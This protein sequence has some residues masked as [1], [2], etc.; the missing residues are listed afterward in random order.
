MINEIE[1]LHRMADAGD[2]TALYK[3][4]AKY[5]SGSGVEINQP[6]AASM[7]EKAASRGSADAQTQIGVFYAA[8]S[9]GYSQDFTKALEWYERAARS[10]HA[11]A[12]FNLALLYWEGEGVR[13]DRQRGWDLMQKASELGLRDRV[14]DFVE[15]EKARAAIRKERNA[16]FSSMS[17]ED[18]LMFQKLSGL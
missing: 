2:A 11:V 5:Y 13:E 9:G 16:I 8:G 17:K 15:M 3:L 7:L 6:L 14:E 4:S 12:I 1:N 10:G 18:Q